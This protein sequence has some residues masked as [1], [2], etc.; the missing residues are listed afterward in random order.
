MLTNSS[1]PYWLVPSFVFS[2]IVSLYDVWVLLVE[3]N[4]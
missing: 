1:A 2:F 3:I 4:R